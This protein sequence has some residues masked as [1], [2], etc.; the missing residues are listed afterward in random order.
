[1]R[2][3]PL[4][5]TGARVSAFCLGTMHFGSRTDKKTSFGILD[6][7]FG[8]GGTFLDTANNYAMWVPGYIGG[9]SESL[10][11]EWMRERGNRDELF[12][13]TKVGFDYPGV[14]WGLRA[15]QIM[16]E[17][18]K[19][20][21]RLGI[22][23][24]DLYYAHRDD[25]NTPLTE[26]M[27][28]FKTLVKAGEVR[29][30]GASNYLAWRLEEARWVSRTHGWPEFCCIQQRYS[31]IRPKPGATFY[32][33]IAANKD[34]LDYCRARGMTLLAYSPLL[35]GAY[36]RPD[37]A[38]PE[39][40]LDPDTDARLVAL[41]AV[42]EEVGATANQVV[43]AWLAQGDPPVIPLVGASTVE[44]LEENLGA[45]EVKLSREQMK[46]LDGAS[47]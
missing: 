25:R 10:L 9:E 47:A 34:S 13:A 2:T 14:D 37:R 32:P 44:Q 38:F 12:I 17:R 3:V 28:T 1:M 33:Q 23:S 30:I 19:S 11:G 29:Y 26:T 40:Y 8:A 45:L 4:G 43:Y 27:E 18:G 39:Q 41:K 42:A 16:T 20:L 6:R 35:N 22:D 36:T 46:H 24:I 7:Y 5:N 31:Y 15:H 21:S